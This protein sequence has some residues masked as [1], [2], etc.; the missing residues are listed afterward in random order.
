LG[1]KFLFRLSHND[2]ETTLSTF[3][4]RYPGNNVNTYELSRATSSTGTT[5]SDED[6]TSIYTTPDNTNF[7]HK[8]NSIDPNNNPI[9]A[10]K[11][12]ANLNNGSNTNPN[13]DV[14]YSIKAIESTA[15]NFYNSLVLVEQ[16]FPHL[17]WITYEEF[18]EADKIEVYRGEMVEKPKTTF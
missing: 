15:I 16:K 10:Y 5:F 1:K 14:A 6:F 3:W 13:P 7:H 11:L 4:G 18:Y 12:K 17:F 8:D 2:S 9:V